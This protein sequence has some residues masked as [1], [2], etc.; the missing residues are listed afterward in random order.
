MNVAKT[1]ENLK[2]AVSPYPI[3]TLPPKRQ[4]TLTGRSI[5]KA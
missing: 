2:N 4:I 5:A 3:L 1:M